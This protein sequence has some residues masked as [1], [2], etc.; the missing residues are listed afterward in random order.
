MDLLIVHDGGLM[1]EHTKK[2]Y[3]VSPTSQRESNPGG[4]AHAVES[5]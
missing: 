2:S 4:T 5:H 1:D 3:A